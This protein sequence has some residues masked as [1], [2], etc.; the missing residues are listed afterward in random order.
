M[1]Y[2]FSIGTLYASHRI[3]KCLFDLIEQ[4]DA[5]QQNDGGKDDGPHKSR[6]ADLP[7]TQK[8]IPEQFHH[9][10]HRIEQ[11]HGAHPA[12]CCRGQRI[13]D[14]GGIHPQ[15]D[16][17]GNDDGQITVLGGQRADD[18][19]APESHTAHNEQ[20]ERKR[21]DRQ[22][23]GMHL[24]G[25]DEI[26]PEAGEQQH[27]NAEIDGGRND[28]S[29]RLGQTREV[30]LAE[31]VGVILERVGSL[32]DTFGKEAPERVA[33]HIEQDL[34]DTVRRQVGNVAED[35]GIDNGRDE[36]NEQDPRGAEDGLLVNQ[37]EVF[38]YEHTDEI[39]VLPQFL[40]VQVEQ[41]VT[42]SDMRITDLGF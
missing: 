16:A 36:R 18:D 26:D 4:H 40:Q 10:S 24:S 39:A 35:D 9:R 38:F 6:H 11:Q 1:I 25:H 14:G 23:V 30:D 5:S 19:A 27:L 33:C 32:V 22:P 17:E 3:H 2:L 20:Y 34:R 37:G 29:D 15:A 31:N 41:P 28:R 7:L 8:H 12:V 13:N 21:K 42:G